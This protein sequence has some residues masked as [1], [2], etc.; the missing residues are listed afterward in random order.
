M[1]DTCDDL[2][3]NGAADGEGVDACFHVIILV[4]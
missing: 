3:R 2:T 1:T 4:C